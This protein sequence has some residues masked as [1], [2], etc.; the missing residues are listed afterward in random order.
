MS[1]ELPF[2]APAPSSIAEALEAIVAELDAVFLDEVDG[3]LRRLRADRAA[4]DAAP[5]SPAA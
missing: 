3:V 2:P 4:P 5:E 1:L